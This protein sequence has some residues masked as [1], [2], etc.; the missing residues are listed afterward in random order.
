MHIGS[1]HS[2]ETRARMSQSH[3]GKIRA[4]SH[5]RSL[6]LALRGNQNGAEALRRIAAARVVTF[7]AA[8]TRALLVGWLKGRSLDFLA[9]DIGVDRDCLRREC[10]RLGLPNRRHSKSLAAEI[11]SATVRARDW[12]DATRWPRTDR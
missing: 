10:A 4:E 5:R 9:Q 6:S 1:H 3:V 8:M 2:L 7:D 11:A 12:L